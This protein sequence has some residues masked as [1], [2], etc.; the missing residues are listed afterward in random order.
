MDMQ[1][2][3]ILAFE[4]MGGKSSHAFKDRGNKYYHGERVAALALRLRE[5]IL[6]GDGSQDEI[7][8]AA[9]WFHDVMNGH[10]KHAE[11]GAEKAR[12]VLMPYCTAQEL[13]AICEIIGV[14]DDRSSGRV[15]FSPYVRL[16]QDADHL[17]HFGT[18]DILMC[19]LYAASR[20]ES[21]IDTRDWLQNGR[22]RENE[23]YRAE[24]NFEL[25]R[26]I[27]DEKTA[28][29]NY[30]TERFCVESAG[31]IWDEE[32]FSRAAFAATVHTTAAAQRSGTR[33]NSATEESPVLG[34]SSRGGGS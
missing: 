31:G 8:T 25:S 29:L 4:L 6:P 33:R 26:K 2:M 13:D 18:Y 5:L 10:E 20:G 1:A 22:P 3:K 17:D 27:F 30:F 24:L 23:R 32:R 11:K 16:H 19:F 28:F 21:I 34:V 9:A 12:E 15:N 7:L 14:H